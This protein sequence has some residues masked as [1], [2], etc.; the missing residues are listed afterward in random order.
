MGNMHFFYSFIQYNGVLWGQ[1]HE[2][3]FPPKSFQI[4]ERLESHSVIGCYSL[5]NIIVCQHCVQTPQ[6]GSVSH[7]PKILYL[8][9]HIPC[10]PF[11]F[12]SD[13]LFCSVFPEPQSL[14]KGGEASTLW[15][16]VTVKDNMNHYMLTTCL[17]RY[18][19]PYY[20]CCYYKCLFLFTIV[21]YCKNKR[22]CL[23]ITQD[24]KKSHWLF[25]HS[26]ARYL[27]IYTVTLVSVRMHSECGASVS[28]QTTNPSLL[29]NW[30]TLNWR[31]VFIPFKFRL[32]ADSVFFYVNQI[33]K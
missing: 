22:Q 19:H 18:L 27:N 28:F 17:L 10:I 15:L 20:Q 8:C 24:N 11:W 6:K 25:S 23:A 13:N 5:A 21:I 3:W 33:V 29:F 9:I 2:P 31:N 26:I 32:Y 1:F 7:R 14:L 16:Q 4:K 30:F 12:V